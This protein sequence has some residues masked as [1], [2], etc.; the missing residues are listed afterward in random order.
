[1]KD[2]PL[3]A[4]DARRI[5]A[6]ADS[7]AREQLADEVPVALL[8]NATPFAVMLATPTDLE[9]FA[10]GFALGEGIVSDASEL[11]V[12]DVLERGDGI[13]LHLAIPGAREEALA[14]RRRTLPGRSGCGLCG[15]ETI[16]AALPPLPRLAPRPAV[17]PQRLLAGFAALPA[18]QHWNRECGALHAAAALYGDALLVREDVGR[19]NALDKVLGAL[20]RSGHRADALLLTSRAS[21]ELVQKAVLGGVGTLAAVSAPT[22]LAVRRARAAGLALYGYAREQRITCYAEPPAA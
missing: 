11:R 4:V 13:A 15:A 14:T 8:F 3:H 7:A 12:V 21:V 18:L 9:D 19:H 6:G 22:A 17:D 20:A 5:D 1:M 2:A 10:Y 16:A